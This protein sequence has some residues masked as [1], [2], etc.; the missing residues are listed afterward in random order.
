MIRKGFPKNVVSK[1]NNKVKVIEVKERDGK[2]LSPWETTEI[3][4]Q[5]RV[6]DCK[7]QDEAKEVGRGN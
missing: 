1:V 3:V 2:R 6:M 5:G 7:G 4:H